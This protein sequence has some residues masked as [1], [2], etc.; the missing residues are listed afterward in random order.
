M[1]LL[2]VLAQE[3][4]HEQRDGVHALA[5]RRQMD[6]DD[7][8]PVVQVFAEA[9]VPDRLLEVAV[10]GRDH[11]RVDAHVALA[12]ETR[13]FPVLEHLEQLR[14]QRRVHLADLVEEDRAAM[15]V[16]ELAELALLGAR[17]RPL[18]EAEQLALEQLRRQ[19]RAVHLHERLVPATR[20]L[21]DRARDQLLTGAA[22]AAHEHGDV[23]V[24]DLLDDLADL[25]HLRVVAAQ[26][27]QLGLG[28]RAAAQ[29]LHFLLER[30]LLERLLERELELLDLER[31][32]QEVGSA[33]AH[34]LHDV[35]RL[36]VARKHHH[37]DV[38]GALLE[39]PQ[40][41]QSVHARQDDVE[42]DD[43][44]AGVVEARE[45]LLGVRCQEHPIALARDE[46]LHVVANAGIVV[47]H[48]NTEGLR[49]V[50]R[51]LHRALGHGKRSPAGG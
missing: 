27:Q 39:P 7:V 40:R 47:D 42:G 29:P 26:E 5:Q 21:E 8:E 2:V 1:I 22:L 19:R 35:A 20:E 31:L 34:R 32:A 36:A 6:G 25:A 10:G 51:M 37:G 46:R 4:V 13:E 41:L 24:G 14:L 48:E 28:A 45:R 11:T 3:V 15:G 16:L 44:G 17:E 50:R 23:G 9:P 38:R 18:L 49:G 12:A 33:Q 30:A 43:V